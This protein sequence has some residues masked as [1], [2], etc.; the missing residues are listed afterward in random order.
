MTSIADALNDTWQFAYGYQG[1]LS[2][3]T[4]PVG[5]T[6]KAVTDNA[7]RVVSVSDP[8]GNTTGLTYDNLDHVTQILDAH[9][10]A[11]SGSYDGNGN[12]LT[13]TDANGNQT[14][15]IYDSRNRM[16]SRADGLKVSE[17]YGYDGNSNLT[18]YT[19]RRGTVDN[20]SYDGLNRRTFAYLGQ[21]GSQYQDTINYSW[22]AG[23][24][25]TQAV[26]SVAGT[27]SRQYSNGTPAYDGLDDL[28]Q[29]TT[30]QG[31][32]NYT[33]DST[34]RRQTMT[35]AGQPQVSLLLSNCATCSLAVCSAASMISSTRSAPSVWS[36]DCR[37]TERVLAIS[38]MSCAYPSTSSP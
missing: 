10:G 12:L 27:I 16:T 18:N 3:V 13:I 30:P 24:R 36:S 21:N 34:R 1:D 32:I 5:N 8:L 9:N 28:L 31:T 15:Y 35:V 22:D 2:Q 17:S 6:T 37:T 11:T 19:D 7:G 23:N 20:F 33:Y 4:D 38:K 14:S 29:E 25:L 26:D